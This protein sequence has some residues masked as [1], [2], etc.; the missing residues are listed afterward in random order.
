MARWPERSGRGDRSGAAAATAPARAH[1]LTEAELRRVETARLGAEHAAAH[2]T[3]RRLAREAQGRWYPTQLLMSA[4]RMLIASG[5]SAPGDPDFGSLGPSGSGGMDTT[6]R[7][8]SP[9]VTS[10]S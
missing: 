6:P 3:Q 5:L 10:R 2:A 7:S 8:S 4:R 1:D 9:A